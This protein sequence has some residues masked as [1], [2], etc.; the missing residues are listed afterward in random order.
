MARGM[1]H[2]CLA[3]TT[4]CPKKKKKK[5]PK[6]LKNELNLMKTERKK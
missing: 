1:S 3:S 5:A 6:S 2:T 4:S